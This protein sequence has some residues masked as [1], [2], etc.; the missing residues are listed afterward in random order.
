MGP[1]ADKLGMKKIIYLIPFITTSLF[2][3]EGDFKMREITVMAG[4]SHEREC[5][6]SKRAQVVEVELD[7]MEERP[8]GLYAGVTSS[9]DVATIRKEKK[10]GKSFVS[11]SFC[12]PKTSHVTGVIIPN[13]ATGSNGNCVADEIQNMDVVLTL[14]DEYGV[15]SDYIK[16]FRPIDFEESSLCERKRKNLEI[17]DA[18]PTITLPEK[19]KQSEY[20]IDQLKVEQN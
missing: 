11:L 8:I 4:L 5:R 19:N 13:I 7:E 6:N 17:S 1:F 14:T 2:A 12:L 15:E 3:Q 9:G 16:A 20:G 18:D 10:E